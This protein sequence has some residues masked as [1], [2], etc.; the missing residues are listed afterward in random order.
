VT[1]GRD[2]ERAAVGARLNLDAM[3]II[4]RRLCAGAARCYHERRGLRY[5]MKRACFDRDGLVSRW[6]DWTPEDNS[7]EAVLEREFMPCIRNSAGRKARG[8]SF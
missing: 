8:F 7:P 2:E 4:A 3:K 5:D 1:V 6:S